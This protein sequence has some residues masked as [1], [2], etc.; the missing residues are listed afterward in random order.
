MSDNTP[1]SLTLAGQQ[2]HDP[3]PTVRD[4][5]ARK[6]VE[7]FDQ[8][9]LRLIKPLIGCK[10]RDKADPDDIVQSALG[11]MIRLGPSFACRNQMWDYLRTTAIN[12]VAELGRMYGT[13]KRNV[14]REGGG[15]VDA[16][17][18]TGLPPD[19]TKR[20]YDSK[21]DTAATQHGSA[22]PS[23]DESSVH[24]MVEGAS[25]DHA[26]SMVELLAFLDDH[27]RRERKGDC[28]AKITK[29]SIEGHGA[30]AIAAE[31]SINR[32]RVE[33]K[34]QLIR[35][36]CTKSKFVRVK[37][38][39]KADAGK[40]TILAVEVTNTAADILRR[41]GLEGHCLYREVPGEPIDRFSETQ[42]VYPRIEE[43]DILRASPMQRPV[44]SEPT[45]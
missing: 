14:G 29:M 30:G 13:Q 33:R 35:T 23:G 37:R 39:G 41:L 40:G 1:G 34:L 36:L 32:R 19:P 16:H 25:P 27:D 18:G 20:R 2:L 38:E 43:G 28:L 26:A 7:A 9:L 5:A 6:I 44:K 24:M 8:Q 45:G 42:R 12:K 21:L 4:Q 10:L 31:L 3:D 11:S 17:E 22:K 15:D